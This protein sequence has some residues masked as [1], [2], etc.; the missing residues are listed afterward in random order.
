[1]FAL[2]WSSLVVTCR[3]RRHFS[4]L[5]KCSVLRSVTTWKGVGNVIEM[6]SHVGFTQIIQFATDLLHQVFHMQKNG[7]VD[8]ESDDGDD[9][10]W[11][12]T[13]SI[14]GD[15]VRLGRVQVARKS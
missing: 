3:H 8:V 10:M 2:F 1:M 12:V 15:A 13:T 14:P 7:L 11:K 6:Y 9:Q 4:S 5:I